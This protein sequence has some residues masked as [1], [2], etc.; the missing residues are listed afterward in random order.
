MARLGRL[1]KAEAVGQVGP[2]VWFIS[3]V[4]AVIGVVGFIEM[5]LLTGAGDAEFP[6]P[7]L[8]V[9][10]RL[11]LGVLTLLIAGIATRGYLATGF[12]RLLLIGGAF[13]VA[14]TLAVSALLLGFGGYLF[15]WYAWL[16][17]L[18][19]VTLITLSGLVGSYTA[20][21]KT[22]ERR[23]GLFYGAIV[24][25]AALGVTGISM[26]DVRMAGPGGL[27]QEFGPSEMILPV[28]VGLLLAAVLAYGKIYRRTR[29]PTAL[30]TSEGMF[31]FMSA[32]VLRLFYTNTW[33]IG[34]WAF[35]GL[36][37]LGLLRIASGLLL[38]YLK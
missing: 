6:N 12:D 14:M 1:Q 36:M 37:A 30:L 28:M 17:L 7:P 15:G 35:Y 22:R 24:L 18:T 33:S 23:T 27:M 5:L 10:V 29:S 16:S 26:F 4:V 20:D 11:L 9:G 34:Q 8:L 3:S 21:K 19:A 31:F 38:A 32:A 25:L 2:D 13:L